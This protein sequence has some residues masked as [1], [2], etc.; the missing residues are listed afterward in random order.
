MC[1]GAGD[2][3]FGRRGAS[4]PVLVLN[5]ILC[6]LFYCSLCLL[7]VRFLWIVGG[8]RSRQMLRRRRELRLFVVLLSVDSLAAALLW[9]L[10]SDPVVP[11]SD[12]RLSSQAVDL[13]QIFHRL[14]L[15][16]LSASLSLLF[17]AWPRYGIFTVSPR[18]N[19]AR[20]NC[21]RRIC[22]PTSYGAWVRASVS[23]SSVSSPGF[24]LLR[25]S[26]SS[27]EKPLP[28]YTLPMARGA[29]SDLLWS[30]CY[31]FFIVLLSCGE[32][33]TGPE[34]TSET[35]LVVLV[36]GVWT[37]TSLNVIILQLYDF[38]VKAFSTH[39]SIASNSLSSSIKDL[40]YLAC[41]HVVIYVYYQRGWIILSCYCSEESY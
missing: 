4:L 15:M 30:V 8:S 27:E 14:V 13:V 37:P 33:S 41:P 19:L 28:P 16:L 17:W 12:F 21:F 34:D 39:S 9:S 36:D 18:S 3:F 24:V 7:P 32:V 22:D 31:I 10:G 38:I 29:A 40:S 6:F 23:E 1:F 20:P 26:S 25:S 5:N 35:T 2:A 11:P